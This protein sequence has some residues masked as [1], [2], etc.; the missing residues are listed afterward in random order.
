MSYDVI[1]RDHEE[2]KEDLKNS[3]KLKYFVGEV[4]NHIGRKVT[5]KEITFLLRFNTLYHGWECDPYGWLLKVG[6]KNIAI[7]TSH[8]D[9]YVVTKEA[10][11]ELVEIYKKTINATQEAINML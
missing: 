5:A 7:L 9:P 10:L 1:V 4:S 11:N 3:G 2:I 6:D 8:G